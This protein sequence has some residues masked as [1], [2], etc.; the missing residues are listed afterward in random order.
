MKD[1]GYDIYHTD[2]QNE[3]HQ[4]RAELR[5][6]KYI[7]SPFD[8]KEHTSLANKT[9]DNDLINFSEKCKNNRSLLLQEALKNNSLNFSSLSL[10]PIFFTSTERTVF[11]SIEKKTKQQIS[12]KI[13]DL[14]EELLDLDFE[15]G[16]YMYCRNMNIILEYRILYYYVYV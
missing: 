8:E 9:L 16:M 3:I 13:Q 15:V 7:Y 6:S 4:W 11:H 10:E 5:H 14:L 2:L 1:D 12:K